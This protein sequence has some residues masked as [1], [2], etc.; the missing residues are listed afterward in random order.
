[1]ITELIIQTKVLKQKDLG[2][3][4][5]ILPIQLLKCLIKIAAG[6]K[7]TFQTSLKKLFTRSNS[8]TLPLVINNFYIFSGPQT[9]TFTVIELTL[10]GP[11]SLPVFVL[12]KVCYDKILNAYF[13]WL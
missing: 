2:V 4:F 6:S 9:Q 3:N 8:P 5:K 12:G 1:M 10:T 11:P 13:K 7:S